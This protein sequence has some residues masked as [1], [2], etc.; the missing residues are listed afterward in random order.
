[1]GR[2]RVRGRRWVI[3]RRWVGECEM[4]RG[5]RWV[6]MEMGWRGRRVGEGEGWER[7][8]G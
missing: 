6:R 2:E 4:G 5:G 3:G 8:T 1:M 7:E